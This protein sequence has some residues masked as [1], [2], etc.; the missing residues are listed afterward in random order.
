MADGTGTR[1]IAWVALASG[2][3]AIVG[4]V[5]VATSRP[6]SPD[7]A[8]AALSELTEQNVESMRRMCESLAKQQEDLRR[9]I[10]E[11]SR[12]LEAARSRLDEVKSV[13]PSPPG[14]VPPE[15]PP[16]K[17]VCHDLHG[18]VVAADNRQNVFVLSIGSK[19]KVE[20]GMEFEVR[21]KA[22]LIGSIVVDKVFP[23]YASATRKPGSAAF[24]VRA[25]DSCDVVPVGK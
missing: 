9:Q 12:E 24:S 2:L 7:A 3:T 10:E 4:I 25:D 20:P 21:R 17:V 18:T 19:D 5:M 22:E 8:G 6:T 23:N 1:V 15:P 16:Q 11:A 13:A 14:D